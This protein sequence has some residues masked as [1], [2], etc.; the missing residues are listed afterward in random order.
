MGKHRAVEPE[1]NIQEEAQLQHDADNAAP[2]SPETPPAPVKTKAPAKRDD[3]RKVPGPSA[4]VEA[5]RRRTLRNHKAFVTALLI[6][7]AV[8]FL[9]CSWWQNQEGGA[10][11]WVG[12]VRAA[13]EAGMIGGLADW[14]AVTALFRHPLGIPIPHTAL[15]RK[16]KDSVG[17]ALSGFVGEN[18]LNA[19]LITDK[20]S[21]ANIPEKLGAWLSQSENAG[22]VS[23]EAGR[24]TA[25]AVRAMDPKDAEMLIQSQLIDKLGEP[26]W[27]P[28]LGKLLEGLI[29]DGKVEPVVNELIDWGHKKVLTMEDSVVTLID[30]RM[31][32]WAP[33]FARSMVGERVYKELVDWVTD[34]KND[35]DHEA[36]H[37]I[38]RGLR[39]FASDLQTDPELIGRVESL[40]SDI[41]GSTPVQ[42]A[43]EAIWAKAAEA[44]ITQAETS[45]SMLREKI[46]E[47]CVKWGTNIQ[48]DPHLRESLD[49]RIQGAAR[50][51]AD[52]YAP[53]VTNIIS[54]TIERW[55]ADEASDKIELMVGKDLQFIRLNGTLVGA[56]AGLVIYAVNHLIF[57]L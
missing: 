7:A 33:R 10:P 8:I 49:N 14:F 19:E 20:V 24:L 1:N 37:A 54:E 44:I 47:L 57:G 17:E 26:Q 27:G 40:K 2:T 36:R 4:E 23:R 55:D 52:N 16:K 15:I 29:E 50:F 22:K 48:E 21:Q 45:D 51:L 28:P 5:Q 38:R 13:A 30:E 25:N 6:V 34:V 32:T 53:E 3:F 43:A 9:A 42:G 11:T 18:F 12:Y 39:N 56:L 46:I 31:P 35:D 41:M